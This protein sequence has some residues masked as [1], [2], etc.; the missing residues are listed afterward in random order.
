ME[1]GPY[2]S[3]GSSGNLSDKEDDGGLPG[4]L[5]ETTRRRFL[6]R[7]AGALA[8]LNA[9]ILGVPFIGAL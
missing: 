7:M 6:A 4:D 1:S 8:A 2:S 3:T 9:L 5:P